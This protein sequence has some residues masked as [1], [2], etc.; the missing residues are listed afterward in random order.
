MLNEV[1]RNQ[2]LK[3]FP[4]VANRVL[5]LLA[6]ED[7]ALV[8]IAHELSLDPTLAAT[9]LQVANSPAYQPRTTITTLPH[10]ISWIGRSEV[11]GLVLGS[12]MA[13]F[14]KKNKNR[15]AQ[16]KEFWKQSFIQACALSR[17]AEISGQIPTGE[18]YLCGLLMDFG[19][20]WMLDR[21]GEEY[22][23]IVVEANQG[24]LPL[25]HLE[26]ERL[27]CTHAEIGRELLVGMK[28]PK[29]FAFV[30]Q[31]HVLSSEELSEQSDSP[32]INLL[33]GAVASSAIADFYCR[34]NRGNSLATLES[35]CTNYFQMTERDIQW[36]MDS[37]NVDIENKAT[38]FSVDLSGMRPIGQLI[39]HATG[40]IEEQQKGE[41][42]LD[43]VTSRLEAENQIL[44]KLVSHLEEH[45]C[46]DQMTGLYNRDFF[47]GQYEEQLARA[48]MDSFSLLVIDI[49]KFKFINDQEG[50]LVGD[51]AIKWTAR[52][53]QNIFK[54]ALVARYGGDEF[55]VIA[56]VADP[57]QVQAAM[58]EVCEA[59]HSESAAAI[60]RDKPL[61]ISIG[62]AI[63]AV[64]E[65]LPNLSAHLFKVADRAM[66]S[67]KRAGGNCGNVVL[68]ESINGESEQPPKSS[69]R[70]ENLSLPSSLS[71]LPAS[72]SQQS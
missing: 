26:K 4:K 38:I 52:K 56:K 53:L 33:A 67:S 6:A 57:Q 64:E 71:S 9:L 10:A 13:R 44:K 51:Q 59:I 14:T 12:E 61:T 29:Q 45:V 17:F 47:Q 24:C 65:P 50:H 66:Y 5:R 72:P 69:L 42:R 54:A 36:V 20:L 16:Y 58:D 63:C 2:W 40:Q 46:R 68:V 41:T 27:G 55:V 49:D 25:H 22:D 70:C 1:Q 23:H 37:V 34:N 3:A 21:F 32:E 48:G 18:A 31:F 43:A 30:A 62:A 11:A 35:I 7:V 15:A 28:L 60:S 19:R 39:G 8:E